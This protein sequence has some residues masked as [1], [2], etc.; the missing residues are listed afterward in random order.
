MERVA[1]FVLKGQVLLFCNRPAFFLKIFFRDKIF[2]AILIGVNS[3][4][5]VLEP[6]CTQFQVEYVDRCSNKLHN[7][8]IILINHECFNYWVHKIRF[9]IARILAFS[10]KYLH[11]QLEASLTMINSRI[12]LSWFFPFK[13]S[14]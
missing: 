14:H 12:S 7:I 11:L 5:F 9:I 8:N 2:H 3:D 4:S 10:R 6:S 13:F 1:F